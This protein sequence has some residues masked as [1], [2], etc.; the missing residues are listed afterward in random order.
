MIAQDAVQN[1]DSR[2]LETLTGLAA[3]HGRTWCYPS[4]DTLLRLLKDFTGRAMHRR[5]LN[6]HLAALE[7]DGYVRRI[8]R[9]MRAKD[10]SLWLRSTCYVLAG[11]WLARARRLFK[12]VQVAWANYRPGQEDRPVAKSAQNLNRYINRSYRQRTA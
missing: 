9:H 2:I 10:G 11:R 6:R 8:R 4:Q 3:H 5:T 7:R 1:G 12:A